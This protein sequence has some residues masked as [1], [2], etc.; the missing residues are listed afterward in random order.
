VFKCNIYTA[1]CSS[2][3]AASPEPPKE[4]IEPTTLRVTATIEFRHSNR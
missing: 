1:K 4:R 3:N 2:H